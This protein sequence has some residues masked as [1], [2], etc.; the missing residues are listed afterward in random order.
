MGKPSMTWQCLL[1]AHK[2]NFILVWIKTR[3]A[4]RGRCFYINSC[5]ACSSGSFS[6]TL[7]A[8]ISWCLTAVKNLLW[9]IHGVTSAKFSSSLSNPGAAG[10]GELVPNCSAPACNEHCGQQME[11]AAW[12]CWICAAGTT[13]RDRNANCWSCC[14][15]RSWGSLCGVVQQVCRTVSQALLEAFLEM[16]LNIGKFTGSGEQ[17]AKNDLCLLSYIHFY[18]S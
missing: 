15:G 16:A 9:C 14:C 8:R 13:W 12:I 5:Q 10:L 17:S 1:A 18:H 6:H 7:S 2:A 11:A 4:G 3:P